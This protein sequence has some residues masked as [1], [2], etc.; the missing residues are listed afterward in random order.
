MRQWFGSKLSLAVLLCLCAMAVSE[1]FQD[2]DYVPVARRGQLSKVRRYPSK[3]LHE[4]APRPALHPVRLFPSP[5]CR[6]FPT[7]CVVLNRVLGT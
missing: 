3:Q 6:S 4:A 1:A 5:L 2:G 7:P